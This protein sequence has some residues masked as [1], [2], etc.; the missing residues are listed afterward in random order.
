MS[1]KRKVELVNL[2][3]WSVNSTTPLNWTLCVICQTPSDQHLITPT[4]AGYESLASNL[5]QFV[6]RSALPSSV[7]IDRM[8]DGSGIENT[9]MSSNAKYHKM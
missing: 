2:V 3:D 9:L 4:Q 8:N 7:R 6:D 1:K 5:Q